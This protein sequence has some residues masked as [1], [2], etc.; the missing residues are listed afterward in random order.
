MN[1]FRIKDFFNSLKYCLCKLCVHAK[2]F[3]KLTIG[4][5]NFVGKRKSRLTSIQLK[6]ED[7]KQTFVFVF[8]NDAMF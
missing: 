8:W 7:L 5:W 3:S 6:K 4:Q 1:K 2:F